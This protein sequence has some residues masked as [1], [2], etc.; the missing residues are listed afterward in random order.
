MCRHFISDEHWSMF[1]DVYDPEY[2]CMSIVDTLNNAYRQGKFSQADLD[3]FHE[4]WKEIEKMEAVWNYGI[5]NFKFE[6]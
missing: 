1:D 4:A 3:F 6:F 5:G 2:S